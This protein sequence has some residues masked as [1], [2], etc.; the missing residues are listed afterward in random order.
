MPSLFGPMDDARVGSKRSFWLTSLPFQVNSHH[1]AF[2][3]PIN[4][5]Y[6]DHIPATSKPGSEELACYSHSGPC[7]NNISWLA[8]PIPVLPS[9]LTLLTPR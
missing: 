2:I 9:R 6:L 5:S 4:A 8:D 7:I 1:L 3:Q